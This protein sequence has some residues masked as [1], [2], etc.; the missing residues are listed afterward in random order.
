VWS[1]KNALKIVLYSKAATSCDV[2]PRDIRK[3]KNQTIIMA[4]R[5]SERAVNTTVKI[6]VEKAEYNELATGF[7]FKY[8][9][10]ERGVTSNRNKCTHNKG[11]EKY[12]IID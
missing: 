10:T 4:I 8:F 2:L 1:F 7:I 11:L 9:R 3:I 6:T 12:H 5:L